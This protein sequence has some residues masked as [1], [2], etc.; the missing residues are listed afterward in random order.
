MLLYGSVGSSGV[1]GPGIRNIPEI[2]EDP[3]KNRAASSR[4]TARSRRRTRQGASERIRYPRGRADVA[5]VD[6]A[7]G[8]LT[9]AFTAF[10]VVTRR[11]PRRFF[12]DFER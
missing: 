3:K 9:G 7:A 2:R 8:F 6:F 12:D 1:R 4:W 5:A 10:L 11:A